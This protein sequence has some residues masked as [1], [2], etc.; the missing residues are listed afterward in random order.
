VGALMMLFLLAIAGLAGAKSD[1]TMPSFG[2]GCIGLIE[3]N[4][5]L[6]PDD[7]PDSL[8][9][10]SAPGSASVVKLIEEA[11]SRHDVRAIL[12]QINS[13]GGSPLASREIYS[14]LKEVNKPKVAYFRELA[15]SG[16][17]YI[18]MGTDYIVSEPDTLTGSIGVRSTLMDLSGLYS[19]LGINETSVKSGELKDIGS[20][21]R[22]MTEKEMT[23]MQ[24]IVDEVF[25]E[26]KGV[27]AENRGSRLRHPQF[28]EIL[29][30]RILTGRQAYSIGLVDEIGGRKA[31]IKRT[32]A[33]LN[34]TDMEI[35]TISEE[36]RGF[37]SQLFSGS[38]SIPLTNANGEWRL[39]Y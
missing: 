2:S 26:F 1:S 34:E 5:E 38:L 13:P 33:M 7:T 16:G 19:K 27:V 32:A 29:D 12:L 9:S 28:E 8:F 30:A 3:I 25:E 37:F 11:D 4:G 31:A 6:L 23:V 10:S 14:A 21:S 18:A 22:P 36:H 17:Y 24:G 35:C 15:A 20:P 39:R